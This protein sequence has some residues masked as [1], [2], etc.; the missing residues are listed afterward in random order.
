MVFLSF[1]EIRTI[2]PF[3]LLNEERLSQK[4]SL[5]IISDGGDKTDCV[6]KVQLAFRSRREPRVECEILRDVA[7]TTKTLEL[8]LSMQVHATSR[9]KTRAFSVFYLPCRKFYI[10]G[11]KSL[12]VMYSDDIMPHIRPLGAARGKC[13]RKSLVSRLKLEELTMKRA[14]QLRGGLGLTA[15][16]I[17]VGLHI[18]YPRGAILSTLSRP[19]HSRAFT[20]LLTHTYTQAHTCIMRSLRSAKSSH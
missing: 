16:G 9:E 5:R 8:A 18:N 6:S 11:L 15:A 2:F 20:H 4:L 14:G 17:K 12:R 10:S 1:A 7:A 19:T 3:S 13:I